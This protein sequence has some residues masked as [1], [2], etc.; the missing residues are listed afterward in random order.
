M[1]QMCPELTKLLALI[2]FVAIYAHLDV[3]FSAIHGDEGL[4]HDY[5][6]IAGLLILAQ[7]F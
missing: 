3:T 4:F 5:D 2:S 1:V 7:G 6:A